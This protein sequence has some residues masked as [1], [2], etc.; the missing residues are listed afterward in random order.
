MKIKLPSKNL[1]Q[2][3]NL[4]LMHE[5]IVTAQPVYN[6]KGKV[7]SATIKVQSNIMEPNTKYIITIKKV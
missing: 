1:K 7:V 5:T 3:L 6:Q 2:N 4:T